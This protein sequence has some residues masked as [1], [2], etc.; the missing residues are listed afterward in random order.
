MGNKHVKSAAES[1]GSSNSHEQQPPISSPELVNGVEA[2]PKLT[3]QQVLVLE[4]TWK[5]LES[6]ISKVGVITFISLFETHPDVQET[7]LPFS[8]MELEELKQ[9]KQLKAH[10][11]RV[12]QSVQKAIARIHEPEKLEALLRDLGQKH[13]FYGA[14]PNYVD[15]IG[16]QFIQAIRPSLEEKWTEELQEAWLQLFRYMS[17]IMKSAME[18]ER[19]TSGVAPTN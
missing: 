15:L 9:S 2:Q 12:M 13:Y 11:L 1:N 6:N 17:C 3:E 5:E 19:I 8:G 10:A 4:E 18:Q 16:P 7:F 14:K